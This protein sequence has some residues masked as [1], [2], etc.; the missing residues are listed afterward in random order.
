MIRNL[1]IAF[2]LVCFFG[3]SAM[4]CYRPGPVVQ[5][6]AT[7]NDFASSGEVD[8]FGN[9]LPDGIGRYE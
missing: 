7:N 6:T 1:W 5:G 3:V 9:E 8:S 4:G 2:A